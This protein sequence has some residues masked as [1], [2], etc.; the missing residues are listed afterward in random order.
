MET[1]GENYYYN[2]SKNINRDFQEAGKTISQ[3]SRHDFTCEKCQSDYT[4]TLQIGK[5]CYFCHQTY[6]NCC[7][8][9]FGSCESCWDKLSRQDQKIQRKRYMKV[10]RRNSKPILIILPIIFFGA[11]GGILMSTVSTAVGLPVLLGGVFGSVGIFSFIFIRK[12]MVIQRK[13]AGDK[14]KNKRPP[15]KKFEK[16]AIA[17]LLGLIGVIIISATVIL[18]VFF[19]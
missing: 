10:L 14:P 4:Q 15:M 19:G 7:K 18:I 9:R 1:M 8:G 17:I 2:W 11:L 5:L 3:I 12:S 6:G 13:I 16:I